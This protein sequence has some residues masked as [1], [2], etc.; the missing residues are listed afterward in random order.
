MLREMSR[1][2]SEQSGILNVPDLFAV[3]IGPS[4]LIV[5]GD[6]TFD[7]DMD[8]P[9]VEETIRLAA[10]ALRQRWPSIE[11]VYLTPVPKPRQRRAGHVNELRVPS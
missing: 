11:Y 8:I 10:N 5:N 6:V 9:A 3:V 7:D 1:L 4:S 2:I